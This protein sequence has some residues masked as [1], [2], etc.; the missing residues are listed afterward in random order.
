MQ[1]NKSVRVGPWTTAAAVAVVVLAVA[2]I[3]VRVGN[4]EFQ[5]SNLLTLLALILALLIALVILLAGWLGGPGTSPG[6][7]MPI[8]KRFPDKGVTVKVPWQ[9]RAVDIVRL[10][11]L[12]L[13][14]LASDTDEFKPTR[15]VMNFEVVDAKD[16]DKVVADF[17]P[18]FE[19]RV[20]IPEEY[21]VG[22]KHNYDAIEMGFW[23]GCR[24]IKL[25]REKHQFQVRPNDPPGTGAVATAM[26]S[27]WADPPFGYGP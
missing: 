17:D 16:T 8:E 20:V 21:L 13:E 9:G 25:T 24:W 5:F 12:P 23:N 14:K 27:N 11:L 22:I 10:P 26:M 7:G 15:L 1:S 3:V 4:V 18:P 19:L 2:E 6:E